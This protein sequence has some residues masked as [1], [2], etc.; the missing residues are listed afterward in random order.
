MFSFFSF[1]FLWFVRGL[2]KL[3][4]TKRVVY[5]SQTK[6]FTQSAIN[7]LFVGAT[8][9]WVNIEQLNIFISIVFFPHLGVFCEIVMRLTNPI[10][11]VECGRIALRITIE[12]KY[13]IYFENFYFQNF[14]DKK[15]FFCERNFI[16]PNI[17][18]NFPKVFF[19]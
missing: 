13:P 7:N 19:G 4:L 9:G 2:L 3:Q 5:H 6:Q 15:K 10:E 17:P 11:L 16:F 14:L 18:K 1:S 8:V 12:V